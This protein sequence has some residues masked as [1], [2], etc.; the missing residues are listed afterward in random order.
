MKRRIFQGR[1]CVMDL[2]CNQ[3][4][5]SCSVKRKDKVNAYLRRATYASEMRCIFYGERRLKA[6]MSDTNTSP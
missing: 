3:E 2:S 4:P 5:L 1:E 6:V